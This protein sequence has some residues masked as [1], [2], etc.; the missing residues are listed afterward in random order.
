MS[1]QRVGAEGAG[2]MLDL[3]VSCVAA[4][5]G[6]GGRDESKEESMPCVDERSGD[7]CGSG[8]TCSAVTAE[9]SC[10]GASGDCMKSW[11]SDKVTESGC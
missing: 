5:S 9:G 2:W 10:V 7:K 11:R 4:V 1:G 3:M 6:S 8:T